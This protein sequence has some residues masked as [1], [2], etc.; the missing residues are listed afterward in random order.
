MIKYSIVCQIKPMLASGGIN[1]ENIICLTVFE[2][3]DN[4]KTTAPK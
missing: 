4:I 3:T 2:D 1:G